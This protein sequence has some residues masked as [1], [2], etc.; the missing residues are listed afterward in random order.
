MNTASRSALGFGGTYHFR[1]PDRSRADGLADALAA[2]GFPL[3][4]AHPDAGGGWMVAVCDPDPY[5]RGTAGSRAR[6]AA[7]RHGAGRPQHARRHR[8]ARTRTCYSATPAMVPVLA[9]LATST[10]LPAQRRLDL[11]LALLC[12]ADQEAGD[13]IHDAYAAAVDRRAPR[14][15]HWAVQA[16]AAVGAATPALLSRWP[17]QPPAVQFALACFAALYPAHSVAHTGELDAFT[18]DFAG[19]QP[20]AYLQLAG[21]LRRGDQPEAIRCAREIIGWHDDADPEW[22]EAPD[23]PTPISCGR[24]LV[25]GTVAIA[26]RRG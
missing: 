23:V 4:F 22:L 12:I 2:F 20:G 26:G 13:L 14:A 3:V 1:A 17:Q 16:R 25:Q 8:V 21:A 6:K 15:Q 5:P 18:A 19:T 11:H 24:L 9:D 7:Y 10:S